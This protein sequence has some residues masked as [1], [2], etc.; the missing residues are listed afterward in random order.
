MRLLLPGHQG[1]S[2]KPHCHCCS[3]ISEVEEEEDVTFYLPEKNRDDPKH[4]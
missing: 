2:P 1:I 4:E 3:N